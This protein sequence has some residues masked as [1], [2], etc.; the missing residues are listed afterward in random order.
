MTASSGGRKIPGW[1]A[2][3]E[4]AAGVAIAYVGL[5]HRYG[6]AAVRLG[7]ERFAHRDIVV[8][9]L[10]TMIAIFIA[11]GRASLAGRASKQCDRIARGAHRVQDEE[12]EQRL[13]IGLHLQLPKDW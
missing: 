7:P 6:T 10:E 4:P 13:R 8:M 2:L 1:V 11:T 3:A 9:A 5:E 12:L